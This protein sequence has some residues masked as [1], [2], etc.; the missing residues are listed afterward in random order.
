M[1]TTVEWSTVYE[2]AAEVSNGFYWRVAEIRTT[3][4]QKRTQVHSSSP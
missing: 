4:R 1:N 2:E 3:A